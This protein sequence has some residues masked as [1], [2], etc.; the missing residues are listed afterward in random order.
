MMITKVKQKSPE[1]F[2]PNCHLLFLKFGSE[3]QTV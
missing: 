2:Y 3:N 1:N